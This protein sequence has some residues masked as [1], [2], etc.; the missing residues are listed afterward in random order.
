MGAVDCGGEAPVVGSEEVGAVEVGGS[1]PAVATLDELVGEEF[2]RAC[3]AGVD[4]ACAEVAGRVPAVGVCANAALLA[5]M[6]LNVT[7]SPAAIQA[8]RRCVLETTIKH[9]PVIQ[10]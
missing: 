10:R 5:A 9:P 4:D 2:A 3:G 7:S 8:D 1:V 6:R